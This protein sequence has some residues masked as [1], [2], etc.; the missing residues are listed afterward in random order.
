MMGAMRRGWASIVLKLSSIRARLTLWYVLLLA[1]IVLGYSTVLVV[2]LSRA[3]TVGLDR[4]LGDGARQAVDIMDGAADEQELKHDFR[5]INVGTVIGLY[6]ADGEHLVVGRALPPPEYHPRPLNG[7]ES[8][9]ETVSFADG[10]S[11]RV[12]TQDV[13]QPGQPPRL[14]LVAR[15]AR[16]ADA[17][18]SEL[19]MLIGVTAPVLLIVAVAGGVFL[20]GRALDPIDQITRTAG[21]IS[22]KDLSRRL[23][24]TGPH[25]EVRRLAATFDHMLDRLDR[26]FERERRF[27]ADASHELRT[28]LAI[29]VSRSGLALERLRTPEEYEAVLREIRDEGLHMGRIV[30]DLLM[31]ARADTGHVVALKERLDAR[32]LVS[33]VAEAMTP[34]AEERGIRMRTD[35]EDALVLVG[36]QTRLTQLLVNLLENALEHTP[37]GGDILVSACGR[38]QAVLLQV[39]DTGSGIAPEHVPHVFERFFRGDRD[40]RRSSGGAG[41][42]LALCQSIALAHGGDIRIDSQVG[43]G[44]RVTVRLPSQAVA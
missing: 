36:D 10:S 43:V 42:G 24:L 4:V 6:T 41:L 17:A 16:F 15:S 9:I 33:S 11:W 3:L 37:A 2:S 7:E 34:L 23:G 8:R 28:P 12:L 27:T 38:M 30:N 18:V 40:S 13:S 14:L 19:L 5:R 35:A 44:T 29:L 31:L 1:L 22:A 39:S 21:A 26:A 20:A 25:D 32:E